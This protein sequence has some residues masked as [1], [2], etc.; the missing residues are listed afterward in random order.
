MQRVLAAALLLAAA[1]PD[2]DPDVPVGVFEPAGP[3]AQPSFVQPPAATCGRV[4]EDD[5]V[6]TIRAVSRVDV[7]PGGVRLWGG[8]SGPT[9]AGPAAWTA[10]VERE[11]R[12]FALLLTRLSVRDGAPCRDAAARQVKLVR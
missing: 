6:G 3:A 1:R 11:G 8:A 12:S 10:L 4:A 5:V 7:G 9:R 2:G